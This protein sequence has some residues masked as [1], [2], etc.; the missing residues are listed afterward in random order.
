MALKNGPKKKLNNE[1][2]INSGF[3]VYRNELVV[4]GSP[5]D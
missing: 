4:A 2:N 5:A 3:A 1:K